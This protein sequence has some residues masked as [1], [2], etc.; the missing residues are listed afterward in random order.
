MFQI[1]SF[2]VLLIHWFVGFDQLQKKRFVEGTDSYV[3]K[4]FTC[5]RK[6]EPWVWK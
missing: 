1:Q 6:I 3:K 5:I 2:R 4:N